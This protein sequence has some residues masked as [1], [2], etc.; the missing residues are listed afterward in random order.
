M[1]PFF[2]LTHWGEKSVPVIRYFK[3]VACGPQLAGDNFYVARQAF[4]ILPVFDLFVR[5]HMLKIQPSARTCL[6]LP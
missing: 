3:Q 2:Q 5:T 1:A 4:G 6:Q